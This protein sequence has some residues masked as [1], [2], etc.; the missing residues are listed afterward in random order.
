MMPDLDGRSAT[1]DS[2]PDTVA[3]LPRKP[4]VNTFPTSLA[5]ERLWVLEQAA[6]GH[7]AASVAGA[8][9]VSGRFDRAALRRSLEA[10]VTRHESLR[11]TFASTDG[12]PLQIVSPYA[13]VS[14][15]SVDL[16]EPRGNDEAERLAHAHA[17]M[18]REVERPFDVAHGPLLR[19]TSFPIAHDTEL[20]CIVLHHLIADAWS[21][22]V[23]VRELIVLY[24]AFVGGHAPALP[25]VQLQYA[26]Y[27]HWQRERFGR[28]P[29]AHATSYWRCQLE[30]APYPRIG[31]GDRLVAGHAALCRPLSPALVDAVRNL[32]RRERTTMFVTARG[33]CLAVLGRWTG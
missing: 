14:M 9:R 2:V 1:R 23:L 3:R 32:G 28:G 19:F 10:V 24:R 8:F 22:P 25:D 6:P 4:G 29:A 15:R 18:L 27:A 7:A 33:A 5:Q 16:R 17:E 21:M 30:G 11:T 13:A 31:S 26:D 20:C 12:V